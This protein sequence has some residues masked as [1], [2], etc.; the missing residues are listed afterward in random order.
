MAALKAVGAAASETMLAISRDDEEAYK[1]VLAKMVKQTDELAGHLP[2]FRRNLVCSLLPRKFKDD[3][4][5]I[6]NSLHS[7]RAESP[8]T[9]V[10]FLLGLH[11]GSEQ[12]DVP[13]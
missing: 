5:F 4:S 7:N 3:V 1:E 12:P 10:D 9:V 6:F 2:D 8:A 13:T 11:Y